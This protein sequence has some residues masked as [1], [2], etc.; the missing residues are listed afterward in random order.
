MEVQNRRDGYSGSRSQ[1]AKNSDLVDRRT[2]S[3]S[4]NP[5]YNAAWSLLIITQHTAQNTIIRSTGNSFYVDG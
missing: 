3:H 2:I 4:R 5:D 1:E